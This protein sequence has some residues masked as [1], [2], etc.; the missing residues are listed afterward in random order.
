[1]APSLLGA[2]VTVRQIHP[3]HSRVSAHH[4]QGGPI[5]GDAET[6]AAAHQSGHVLGLSLPG[7][8][9]VIGD[10][11]ATT[12]A[13]DKVPDVAG[14]RRSNGRLLFVGELKTPPVEAHSLGNIPTERK[15]REILGQIAEYMQETGRQYGF[16]STYETIFLQQ[17]SG[18]GNTRTV[19]AAW[20]L[21]SALSK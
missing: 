11:R 3:S 10:S 15:P 5:S 8:G 19:S 4:G 14:A 20:C 9:V 6:L 1:M 16:M 12:T 21:E 17:V 7:E 2:T 13:Y 18:P